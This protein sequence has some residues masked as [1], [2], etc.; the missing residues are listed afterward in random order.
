MEAVK[1]SLI[2]QL[3]DQL[4]KDLS[5][6]R[7]LPP[8]VL[9]TITDQ[10]GITVDQLATFFQSHV[11]TLE[12]AAIDLTFSPLFTPTL[13]DRRP[14]FALLRENV[15]PS[16]KSLLSSLQ[17]VTTTLCSPDGSKFT[18]PLQEVTLQRY[19]SR[20]H[21]DRP[22]A[23]KVFWGIERLLPEDERPLANALARESVWKDPARQ[24]MLI[25]FMT[26]FYKDSESTHSLDKLVYLTDFVRTYRPVTF[27]DMERQL[28]SL[29]RSCE[30]DLAKASEQPFHD[31]HL[32][33]KYLV[34]QEGHVKEAPREMVQ[35][36]YLRLMEQAKSL[37]E[38]YRLIYELMP[39]YI[40]SLSA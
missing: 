26:A 7:T 15:I 18:M 12:D 36:H 6:E 38:D 35:L 32:K 17:P 29:V 4:R 2:A 13:Q 1:E 19:V 3:L 20:L 25:A 24:E 5:Q 8:Q 34:R 28:D 27:F 37:R 40:R 39:D 21:L 30:S 22:L 23:E 16:L 9:N 31:A 33:E 11:P 14:Y 10:F